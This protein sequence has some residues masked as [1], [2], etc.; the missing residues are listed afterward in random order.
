MKIAA[1]LAAFTLALTL[2]SCGGNKSSLPEKF[3]SFMGKDISTGN[4]V[5]DDVFADSTVTVVNIWFTGCQGCVQEMPQLEKIS[6]A[7][8]AKGG[9]MIGMCL[10]VTG[11][12]SRKQALDILEKK[13]VTYANLSV[14]STSNAQKFL[15]SI[16][17]FP[18]TLLVDRDGNIIGKPI[19]GSV[20]T[21]KRIDALMSRVDEIV[22]KDGDRK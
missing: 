7:L 18:T 15:N 5:S 22:A 3:P 8:K 16:M 6:E 19:V 10:D 9:K 20:D 13:G 1:I 11:E 14:D 21:Q 17:A 4:K 2:T 12:E